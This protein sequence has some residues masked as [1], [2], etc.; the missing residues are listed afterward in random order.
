MKQA[1]PKQQTN[2]DSLHGSPALQSQPAM[3][4]SMEKARGKAAMQ[5]FFLSCSST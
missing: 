1:L 4:D 5:G 2:Y 3:V